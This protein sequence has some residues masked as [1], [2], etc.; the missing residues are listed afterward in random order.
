VRRV[1]ERTLFELRPGVTEVHAH[2]AVDAPELRALAPDWAKRVDDH[3]LLVHDHD[4]RALAERA[5]VHLVG[6]LDLRGAM[7]S[8]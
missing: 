1:L 2:P 5:G 7:R 3:D 4:I 8:R 6:Y